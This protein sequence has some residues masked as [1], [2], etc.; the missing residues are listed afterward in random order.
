MLLGLS[1]ASV[2]R[3]AAADEPSA[4]DKASARDLVFAGRELRDKGDHEGALV[5]FKGA[6]A[7][8]RTPITA[9]ELGREHLALGQL[10]EASERFIEAAKM[11]P[12]PTE[13]DESRKARADAEKLADAVAPRIPSI[14][15]VLDG[16]PAGAEVTVTLDGKAVPVDALAVPRKVNPGPHRVVAKATDGRE[17]TA[18]VTVKEGEKHELKLA[19]PPIAANSNAKPASV[20]STS[21]SKADQPPP[22]PTG[23]SSLAYVGFGA[24]AVGLVGGA[25]GGVL[26][27]QR[28]FDIRACQSADSTTNDECIAKVPGRNSAAALTIAATSLGFVGLGIGILSLPDKKSA[29]VTPLIGL[30]TIGVKGVF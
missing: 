2:I 17:Q 28:E 13:T 14:T 20:G 8:F 26:W 16:V 27:V 9:L 24:A 7:L 4:A 10:V 11:P 30:G 29:W 3:D 21:A 22:P 12:R 18:E 19:L 6:Y 5:K 25:I 23:T 1:T 15:V